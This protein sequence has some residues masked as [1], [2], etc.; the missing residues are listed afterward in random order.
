MSAFV[1]NLREPPLNA[2]LSTCKG[3]RRDVFFSHWS[4]IVAGLCLA[5][6]RRKYCWEI[7]FANVA[8]GGFLKPG[9]LFCCRIICMSSGRCHAAMLSTHVAGHGSRRNSPNSG[10]PSAIWKPTFLLLAKR[11]VAVEC[12][13]RG[14]GNIPLKQ[15]SIM[16]VILI[17][18]ITILLSMATS[19]SHTNGPL[20][21]FIA[22]SKRGSFPGTGP[23]G[24]M[25]RIHCRLKI[26]T[27]RLAN[28]LPSGTA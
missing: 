21:A 2:E 1:R 6:H 19:S 17:I 26:F 15:K 16:N 24:K 3:C 4:R 5:T 10:W 8:S 11:R 25:V 12:G 27:N 22:G 18:S 7:V 28:K 23:A 20:P 9:R 14:S 13:S